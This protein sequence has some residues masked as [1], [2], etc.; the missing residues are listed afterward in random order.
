M[1]FSAILRQKLCVQRQEK[2]L[3]NGLVAGDDDV[4]LLL[5]CDV[6]VSFVHEGCLLS[7]RNLETEAFLAE[8]T[9]SGSLL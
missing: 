6:G 5:R 8:A 7:F 4:L 1:C 2:E 9:I 3:Q